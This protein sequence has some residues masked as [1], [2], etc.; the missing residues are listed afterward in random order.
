MI[1][2]LTTWASIDSTSIS[3]QERA[4]AIGSKVELT[5]TDRARSFARFS[6]WKEGSAKSSDYKSLTS[7]T[8]RSHLVRMCLS[9]VFSVEYVRRRLESFLMPHISDAAVYDLIITVDLLSKLCMR[10]MCS[11]RTHVKMHDA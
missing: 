4:A 8:E 3:R 1:S 7:D 2:T 5:A 11:Y 10:K 6:R 9:S